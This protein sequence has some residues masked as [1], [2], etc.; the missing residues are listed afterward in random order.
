MDWL[1]LVLIKKRPDI[2]HYFGKTIL[3]VNTA[4]GGRALQV[5]SVAGWK[6]RHKPDDPFQH[7]NY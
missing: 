2:L 4:V 7:N 3:S 6:G 5:V 1:R